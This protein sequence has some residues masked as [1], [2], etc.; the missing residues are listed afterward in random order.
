MLAPNTQGENR[1]EFEATHDFQV[2][3]DEPSELEN[4]AFDSKVHDEL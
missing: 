3:N 4:V 2:D 1:V